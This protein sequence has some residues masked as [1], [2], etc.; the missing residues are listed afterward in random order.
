MRN[1]RTVVHDY[2]DSPTPGGSIE[3]S[4]RASSMPGLSSLLVVPLHAHDRVL[5]AVTF[6]M[7][8]GG[9]RHDPSYRT[10]AEE[11]ASRVALAVDNAAAYQRVRQAVGARDET[12]A[13]VSHDLRNPL[14][15]IRMCMSAL[16]EVPPPSAETTAD[17]LGSVQEA[18]A[19]MSRIIQ[20]LLDVASMD[21]GRLSLE[22]QIES[23]GPLLGRVEAMFRVVADD[24]GIALIL[25][26][27]GLEGLPRVNIDAERVEQVLANLL[28]NA[29]KFT[30]AGGIVRIA[31]ISAPGKITVTVSDT[32]PGIAPEDLPHIFDRFW[33]GRRRTKI[34]ST[35]LGL[36]ISRGI[37]Q[38][39]GGRIWA[40]ST[41]GQGTTVSFELPAATPQG[42]YGE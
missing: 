41:P 27:T 14:S 25:E 29:L 38:A 36:A 34:R 16:Q 31:A 19:L 5:G 33:H 13:I 32:G 17:L 11:F 8:T 20:D 4:F 1:R 22:R 40:E 23:I 6:A 10:L 12:L 15:A 30:D 28:N 9:R 42:A 37:V 2:V 39:H 18:T 7:R 3:D 21:S 24:R 35:G 26:H